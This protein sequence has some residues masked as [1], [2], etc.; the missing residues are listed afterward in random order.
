MSNTDSI[1]VQAQV[2]ILYIIVAII[3]AMSIY[4]VYEVA[5]QPSL[6][7]NLDNR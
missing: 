5:T 2:L 3:L 4:S 1:S 6:G 7:D